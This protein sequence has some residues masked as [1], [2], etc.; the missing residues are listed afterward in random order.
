MPALVAIPGG[1][2]LRPTPRP[3]PGRGQVLLRVLTSALCRTDVY[4]ATGQ[5]NVPDGRILGHEFCGRVTKLGPNA[6]SHLEGQKVAVFPWLGCG[7]CLACQTPYEGAA[8]CAQRRFLGLDLD[9]AFAPEIVVPADRVLPVPESLPE[10]LVAF[11]EPVAAALGVT[12]ALPSTAQIGLFGDNR[13][14]AL[15]QR[16]LTVLGHEVSSYNEN[17][18]YALESDPEFIEDAMQALRPRGTLIAKSRPSTAVPW[19]LRLQVE[20]E[21]TVV[22]AGYGRFERAVELL[23]SHPELLHDMAAPPRPLSQWKEAIA[24]GEGPRKTFFLPEPVE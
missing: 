11:A 10:Q 5:L 14:S 12:K 13:L 17:L 3:T 4:A 19:P 22:A 8:L 21:I 20:K 1:A 18:A 9:G 2:E 6:P 15:S 23:T 16:L 7:R 24:E